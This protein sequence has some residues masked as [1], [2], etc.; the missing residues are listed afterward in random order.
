MSRLQRV[1]ERLG[2]CSVPPAEEA[3]A[4][5]L[6]ALTAQREPELILT[7]RA[8]HMSTHPGEVAFPGGRRDPD[9]RDLVYT[10][11]RESHEEIALDPDCVEIVGAL[12]GRT[13]RHGVRV[14]PVVA[15]VPAQVRLEPNRAELD[16]VYRIPL[17]YFLHREN[18]R[19]DR[20]LH[21]GRA[22]DVP[23]YPWGERQVWGLTAVMLIDLLDAVFD[24]H[25][26][27]LR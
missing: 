25:V 27:L 17:D 14:C 20:V 15:I 12:P 18:L 8:A 3:D 19:I 1:R 22:K 9:D 23:W 5:V 13:S 11:L 24:F 2:G 6:L 10:A 7:L 21:Q 16:E 4:A 26:E